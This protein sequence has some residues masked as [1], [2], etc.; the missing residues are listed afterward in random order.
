MKEARQHRFQPPKGAAD[1]LLI[2]HGETQAAVRGESFAMVEGQGD[3]ALHPDG[4]RQALAVGERLKTEPIKAIYVTTMQRT[5]QTAAPLARHLGVQPRVER[6]LREV[7]LGDWDGG[8]FR[9]RA[10]ENDP[11]IVRARERHEWGELPGA[12][13]TAQLQERVRRGLLRI[14]AAH[15]D[16]LVAVVVHGGVVG[17]ALSIA[18]GARGF[19]FSGAA[20]GSISRLVVQGEEMIVRGF[21]D[22]SHL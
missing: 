4:E 17:A 10:A 7:F 19:A 1:L 21:N 6:D 13:T 20:N 8:E 11:A 12:E 14:A 3:P 22:V 15:A 2:R 5:H 16:E 9:F 18:T